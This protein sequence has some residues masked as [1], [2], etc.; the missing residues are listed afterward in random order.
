MELG[1]ETL[2]T[3]DTSPFRHDMSSRR[4]LMRDVASGL[5]DLHATGNIHCDIT[6]SNLLV[7]EGALLLADFGLAHTGQRDIFKGT[8]FYL[9]SQDREQTEKTDMY[10]Y[11]ASMAEICFGITFSKDDPERR[12]AYNFANGIAESVQTVKRL[13]S[14]SAEAWRLHEMLAEEPL[15][16]SASEE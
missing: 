6:P 1:E 2:S 13:D 7:K 14:L 11:G 5:K 12:N 16:A 3:V 9:P 10:M 15:S 8:K 4:G